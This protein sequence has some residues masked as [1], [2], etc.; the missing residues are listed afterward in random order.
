MATTTQT[1]RKLSDP[2]FKK[3]AVQL[4]LARGRPLALIAREL[5]VRSWPLR[6]WKQRLRPQL[7]PPPEP[8]EAR[9][10]R[11]IQLERANLQRRHQRDILKK[12]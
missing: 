4:L 11:V 9:R 5:G 8:R 12:R 10:L 6:D 2:E 1:N 7:A 3:P